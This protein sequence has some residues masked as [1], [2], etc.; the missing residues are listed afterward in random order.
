MNE[1]LLSIYLGKI[2][3]CLLPVI[4][5][6]LV[7]VRLTRKRDD[8]KVTAWPTIVGI[9][10]TV[11][12]IAGGGLRAPENSVI[13]DGVSITTSIAGPAADFPSVL[14]PDYVARYGKLLAASVVQDAQGHAGKTIDSA[15]VSSSA[16]VVRFGTKSV[17]R[18]IVSI[19]GVEYFVQFVG[20]QGK[21]ALN[22]D[23]KSLS[24]E[25]FKIPDSG[26]EKAAIENLGGNN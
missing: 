26:C 8:F 24:L 17:I 15:S 11:S 14:N 5:G 3:G 22:I 16:S 1:H 13:I 4:I 19:P 20:V 23:C 2:I 9:L 12:A 21:N 18:T 6:I 7:S 10:V 25:A